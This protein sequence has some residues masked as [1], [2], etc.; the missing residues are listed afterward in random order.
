M[1]ERKKELLKEILT[2]RFKDEFEFVEVQEDIN[3]KTAG[4]IEDYTPALLADFLKEY[5]RMT[6]VDS[7]IQEL[8]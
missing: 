1:T 3:K 7:T 5:V 4:K 6:H 2:T 8:E